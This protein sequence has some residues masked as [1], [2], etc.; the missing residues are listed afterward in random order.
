MWYTWTY[1]QDFNEMWYTWMYP[2]DFNEMWYTWMYPQDFNEMWY[3]WTYPQDFNEMWYTWMYPQ[4]I[5][6]Y[7]RAPAYLKQQMV[8][9]FLYRFFLL[10]PPPP[11][12]SFVLDYV[13]GAIILQWHD[14][15]VGRYINM[16]RLTFKCPSGSDIVMRCFCRVYDRGLH[17]AFTR[18]RPLLC[19]LGCSIKNHSSTQRFS[20]SI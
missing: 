14:V 16:E 7:L 3:T 6:L 15:M 18:P 11:P 2:Q 8:F 19:G 4:D 17:Y 9:A 1:P 10:S 13:D 12:L 20:C 5:V